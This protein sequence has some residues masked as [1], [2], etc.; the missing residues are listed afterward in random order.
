MAKV[1]KNVWISY[2]HS[3]PLF[4]SPDLWK[5]GGIIA[6]HDTIFTI[7]QTGGNRVITACLKEDMFAGPKGLSCLAMMRLHIIYRLLSNGPLLFEVLLL[8]VPVS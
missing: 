6:R 8:T 1:T 3:G 7:Y 2:G 5:S 4:Q